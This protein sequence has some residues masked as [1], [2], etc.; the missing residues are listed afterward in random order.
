MKSNRNKPISEREP[1][2]TPSTIKNVLGSI[3]QLINYSVCRKVFLGIKK[4]LIDMILL[5]LKEMYEVLRPDTIQRKTEM[6]QHKAGT[7]LTPEMTWKWG[8]SDLVEGIRNNLKDLSIET[9]TLMRFVDACDIRNYLMVEICLGNATRCSNLRELRVSHFLQAVS[10]QLPN[11]MEINSDI[12]KTSLIYGRKIIHLP[13]EIFE[14]LQTFIRSV[15]PEFVSA[16]N[17]FVFSSMKFSK[18]ITV[19]S[20]LAHTAVNR[21][22]TCGAVSSG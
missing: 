12:Y 8:R 11:A 4:E 20:Q 22:I 18:C 9:E 2:A 13:M 5:R 19:L 7:L 17:P 21:C 14:E 6:K 16:E 15:R 10:S 3:R 1:C